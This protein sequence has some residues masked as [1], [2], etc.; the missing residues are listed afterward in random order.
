MSSVTGPSWALASGACDDPS[1]LHHLIDSV[2]DTGNM[3]KQLQEKGPQDF[4]AKALLEEHSEERKNEAQQNKENLY[5]CDSPLLSTVTIRGYGAVCGLDV[6]EL[7]TAIRQS[8]ANTREEARRTRKLGADM[9]DHSQL[10]WKE[11]L[12]RPPRARQQRVW[13][14]CVHCT[15]DCGGDEMPT[16]DHR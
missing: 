6:L 3:T 4:K 10:S 2:D 5:Q 12:R 9:T 8:P 14:G 15:V 1:V 16:C 7:C 13:Q 11:T